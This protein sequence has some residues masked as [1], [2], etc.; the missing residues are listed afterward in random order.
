MESS[1]VQLGGSNYPGD[2]G[3]EVWKW[4]GIPDL[5]SALVTTSGLG[6]C[7]VVHLGTVFDHADGL[8]MDKI[9]ARPSTHQ[10]GPEVHPDMVIERPVVRSGIVAEGTEGNVH[11]DLGREAVHHMRLPGHHSCHRGR[12]DNIVQSDVLFFPVFAMVTVDRLIVAIHQHPDY[13]LGKGLLRGCHP[14]NLWKGSP[15]EGLGLLKALFRVVSVFRN[16]GQ[17]PFGGHEVSS[18]PILLAHV[19]TVLC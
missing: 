15:Y 8:H 18:V 14:L 2:P 9:A 10:D 5:L 7:H 13:Q 6:P 11:L 12:M 4:S 16:P 17:Q 1:E 3:L 19:V